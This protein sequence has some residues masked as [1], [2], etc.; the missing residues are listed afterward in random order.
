MDH[1]GFQPP[2]DRLG[3]RNYGSEGNDICYSN[4]ILSRQGKMGRV[5]KFLYRQDGITAIF[6]GPGKQEYF[7]DRQHKIKWLIDNNAEE[8][9]TLEFKAAGALGKKDL[10]KKEIGKD[11]SAFANSAGGIIFYGIE[12][13]EHKAADFSFIDGNEFTKEWIEN[14]ISGQIQR[15]IPD[16]RVIPIRFDGDLKKSI[17]IIKIPESP[18][19]PHMCKDNRY[20][21]RYEF[22]SEPMEEYEVRR[23]YN[24]SQ[25]PQLEIADQLVVRSLGMTKTGFMIKRQSFEIGIQIENIGR[26]IEDRYKL[27]LEIPSVPLGDEISNPHIAE[28]RHSFDGISNKLSIPNSSPIF[29]GELNKHF[30]F[31]IGVSFRSYQ[32]LSTAPMRCKLYFS[33]GIHEK[34]FLLWEGLNDAGF[35]LNIRHFDPGIS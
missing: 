11:V 17:Y 30:S 13:K 16:L 18:N 28:F 1:I 26:T 12:E 8:S 24:S 4:G 33:G 9:L 27:E 32:Q 35:K 15:K 31:N 21:K 20:Y 6:K 7:F 19:V 2:I 5:E 14:V 3:Y 34:D 10:K 22:K 29:Q 25:R 23:A